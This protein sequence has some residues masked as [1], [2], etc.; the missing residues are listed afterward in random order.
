MHTHSWFRIPALVG[1]LLVLFSI[2]VTGAAAQQQPPI[3][4]QRFETIATYSGQ[5]TM[6]VQLVNAYGQSLG[7]YQYSTTIEI[8]FGTPQ[9]ASGGTQ[10][11]NP[12]Y[13]LIQS[14]P[15]IN[16]PG[17]FSIYSSIVYSG[18]VF[19]YWDIQI[20]EGDS[21]AGRLSD[22]H[23]RE[24]IALNSF[25]IPRAI[26]PGLTMPYTEAMANGTILGGTFDSAGNLTMRIE[27][28]ATHL[29]NPFVID[30]TARLTSGDV[31]IQS[32]PSPPR[33]LAAALTAPG[34]ITLT[35]SDTSDNETHFDVQES[36]D[37]GPWQMLGQVAANRTVA[38]VTEQNGFLCDT[39]YA[40]RIRA[41]NTAAPSS[42]S[43]TADVITRPCS[44]SGS[45]PGSG[46]EKI[47]LPMIATYR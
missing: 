9:I 38:T 25:T 13:L 24:S 33:N 47:Y 17:E 27:G 39:T 18:V 20:V 23:V 42:Y 16:N 8:I 46:S 44:G 40:Y 45:G 28:N 31:P 19:Q 12:F 10:E 22:N 36:I 2:F 34:E 37:N 14:T 41:V 43:N 26:A 32:P 30:V 4:P 1:V 15:L 3:A 11:S 6:S 35:W 29:Q 7:W 5:A 21:F